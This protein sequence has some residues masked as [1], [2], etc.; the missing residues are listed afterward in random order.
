MRTHRFDKLLEQHFVTK[1]Q[2]TCSNAVLV[3]TKLQQTC[4]NAVLVV[5]KLQQTCSNAVLV[6]HT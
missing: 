4:S 6:V 3:V 5:T 2:Q 1:L